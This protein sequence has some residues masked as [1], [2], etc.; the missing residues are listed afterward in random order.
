MVKVAPALE[1]V[2]DFRAFPG[3]DFDEAFAYATLRH[4]ETIGRPVG[5]RKW[6]EDM[7]SRTGLALLAGK[8]GPKPKGN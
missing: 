8:R 1:R 6:L 5:S 4:A 3:E 7:E 2:G